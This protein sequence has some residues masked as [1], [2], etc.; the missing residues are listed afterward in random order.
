MEQWIQKQIKSWS[1][2][3][4]GYILGARWKNEINEGILLAQSDYTISEIKELWRNGTPIIDPIHTVTRDVA[5]MLVGRGIR[6]H[7][8]YVKIK[9]TPMKY[10]AKIAKIE[11]Y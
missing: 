4:Y 11:L 3:A 8:D 10:P 7:A 6:T 1:L 9:F 5:A 2:S